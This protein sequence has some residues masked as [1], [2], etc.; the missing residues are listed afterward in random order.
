MYIKNLFFLDCK[1]EISY[2]GVVI[3]GEGGKCDY[4]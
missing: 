1:Q 4:F 3:N 2:N